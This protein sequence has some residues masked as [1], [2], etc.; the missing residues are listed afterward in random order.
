MEKKNARMGY[1]ID[2]KRLF[3]GNPH[4]D[5]DKI[6]VYLL[7]GE[8][9]GQ[10]SIRNPVTGQGKG[11]N[12]WTD[13]EWKWDDFLIENVKINNWKIDDSFLQHMKDNYWE[14]PELYLDGI[15]GWIKFGGE[16]EET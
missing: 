12:I 1:H 7:S 10:T 4:P 15:M 2:N 14:V 8:L 3:K 16:D 9:E 11:L 6:V 5:K 13:G